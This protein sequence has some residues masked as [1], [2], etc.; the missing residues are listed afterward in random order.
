MNNIRYN[1]VARFF[2]WLVAGLIVSQYILAKLAERAEEQDRIV[3]QLGLLANHKSVGITILA[4]A[5]LR[6]TWRLTHSPPKLP[7]DMPRWQHAISGLVHWVIYGLIFALPISGW[8]MSSAKSYSVSVFNLFVLPDFVAANEALA[9]NLLNIHELLGKALFV[10]AVLHILAAF[11][12]L[13]IDKD[14]VM[15]RMA[16]WGGVALFAV[17]VVVVIS[18]FG[19]LKTKAPAAQKDQITAQQPGQINVVAETTEASQ[20]AKASNLPS[21]QIDYAN[22]YIKFSGDQAG[23]S[24]TGQWQAWQADIRF[25]GTNLGASQ[26]DVTIDIAS[27]ASGDAERDGYIVGEDFFNQEQYAQASFVASEFTKQEGG[28]T[29]IG[30]LTMKNTTKPAEFNFTISETAQGNELVGRAR[31]DRLAW[32]IGTGDW[33]DTSWVGQFVD[34]EVKVVTMKN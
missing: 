2:H 16:G 19:I 7:R 8:L 17:C 25:S 10:V 28:Y 34:V 11:K 21:W 32:N 6:L 29:T 13:F 4:L 26:F 20:K 1:A 30:Q 5:M 23:A 18:Q 33:A 31:L 9:N 12:H 27:V 3:A 24:F 15:Q 14:G 22:S